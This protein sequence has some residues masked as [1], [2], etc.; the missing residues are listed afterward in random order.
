MKKQ[1]AVRSNICLILMIFAIIVAARSSGAYA[2]SVPCATGQIDSSSGVNLRAKASTDS[3]IITVLAD[4]TTVKIYREVFKKK[5]SRLPENIWYYVSANGLK[6]YVRSDLVDNLC[7]GSIKGTV[8]STVAYRWGAGTGMKKAGSYA[9][10]TEVTVVLRAR[11]VKSARGSSKTWYKVRSGNNYY[12]VS[13]KKI[14]L[15]GTAVPAGSVLSG[16]DQDLSQSEFA[17]MT[18]KEF[19]AY[20]IQQGF[21]AKY[22]KKLRELHRKHPNWVFVAYRTGIKW[23]DAMAAQT[24]GSRSLVSRLYPSS[25]RAG[26]KQYEPGWYKADSRVVAYYMD[27][28]NFLNE[29]GIY[30][31]ED[32]SYKASY[33]TASAVSAILKPTKLPKNGFKATLFVK[34]GAKYNVSPVFLASRARQET[35]GGSD[36]INGTKVLGKK[37]YN[38]FNIGAFGGNPLYNGLLYAYAKG[39]TTPSKAVKGG[40]QELAKGYINRGQNTG[41][42]QRFNVRNGSSK[43]GTHQYMTNIM[44]PYCEALS[45]RNSYNKYGITGRS[46]VFEIPVYEKMPSKTKLP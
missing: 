4:D 10:G 18:D 2:A 31:F 30:M 22:R 38:P 36:A 12:Y 32:L 7:Y 39:W 5:K 14:K 13:S 21:P 19:N 15:S 43:A 44:A 42:Y 24:K 34:A 17:S 41:Y 35:G 6:G 11:P 46:L 33:Q 25:Y 8:K 20:L 45:T 23:A 37:V 16:D 29:D 28:R 1:T 3:D 9:K 40:A 26:S 27:P